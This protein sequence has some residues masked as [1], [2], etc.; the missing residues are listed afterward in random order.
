MHR[1][2]AGGGNAEERRQRLRDQMKAFYGDPNAST[3]RA[4]SHSST[5]RNPNVPPELDLDSEYFNVNRY[6]TDL[7]KRE[8]LK[9]LV[10][11]DTELLRR[12]RRLD[13]ELQELVYRNYARFIS[14][15]E[16]IREMKDNVVEMDA[17]LQTLSQNVNTIDNISSQITQ[18]L[19]VHRGHIEDTITANRM[20]KKVQF[21]TSL[22]TTMR[23]LID[24]GDYSVGV[25][26]WVAGDGFLSKHKS[27]SSITQIQQNCCQL[28]KEL[29][30]AIEQHMCS[31]PLD[32]PDAM[33][34]LRGYVEDLRLLRATSLFESAN[35]IEE[36][37]FEETVLQTLMKSVLASFQANVATTQRSLN[38][39]LAIP[40]DLQAS[41]MAK[42]EASLA[43]V[44]L[45]E[46]LVQLKNACAMLVVNTER[47]YALLDA[48]GRSSSDRGPAAPLVA[49]SIQPVL[50]KVLQ[51]VSQSLADF[52]MVHLDAIAMDG[53]SALRN[54]TA[55]AGA[56]QVATTHLV[57]LLS[58]FVTAM[59]T[60]GEIYLPSM[61]HDAAEA[62]GSAAPA[63]DTVHLYANKVHEVACDVV[64]QCWERIQERLLQGPEP[65]LL[66]AC[67]P[68]S[69]SHVSVLS[70]VPAVDDE[71]AHEI[72]FALTRF[73]YASLT[74]CLSTSL[75]TTLL[76]EEGVPVDM[77]TSITTGL[78]R[79]AQQLQHRGIVLLGQLEVRLV[80]DKAF[81]GSSGHVSTATTTTTGPKVQEVLLLLLPQWATVY[82][83][84]KALPPLKTASVTAAAKSKGGV[85][86]SLYRHRDNSGYGGGTAYRVSGGSSTGTHSDYRAGGSSAVVGGSSA[87]LRG[88]S[89]RGKPEVSYT[90]QVMSRLQM[91]VNHIFA[92]AETWLRTE[93][94][95]GLPSAL[96]ACVVRYLLQGI[97]DRVRDEAAYTETQFQQLQVSCTFLL[98]ALV[99]PTKGSAPR[100]WRKEWSEEDM[101]D[102]QRLLN[103]VCACAYDKYEAKVPL[104]TA[105]L[106]RVVETAVHSGRAA[107]EAAN[108]SSADTAAAT[109]VPMPSVTEVTFPGEETKTPS[110]EPPQPAPIAP[111]LVTLSPQPQQLLQEVRHPLRDDLLQSS[112]AASSGE[113]PNST[114]PPAPTASAAAPSPAPVTSASAP[115][116]ATP[117][118]PAQA[119]VT[120]PPESRAEPAA[121]LVPAAAER[122][123][124]AP[125]TTMPPPQARFSSHYNSDSRTERVDEEEELPL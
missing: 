38:A 112:A 18:Q 105:V 62:S 32:D 120:L 42:R 117:A 29:Y 104:P 81:S 60:L 122:L 5:Q 108:I 100:Q 1:G 121:S 49:K 39:A 73:L 27:I 25:K 90:R 53:A 31:Y 69:L 110:L 102:V 4:A 56:L 79:A 87:H 118:T 99:S 76:G 103:E 2:S 54:P 6:I 55:S 43:Q 82:D 80:Y 10:E 95:V 91:S 61:G 8:T 17:K 107:L 64:R 97:L 71:G 12:V 94:V 124:A 11:T 9:G 28:A 51:A 36:A 125:G 101:L 75:R 35:I 70:T 41:E 26:Y 46:P 93:P 113:T 89:S 37:P 30:H 15:T 21:L 34:R 47:V 19:Q 116:Q 92:N 123:A 13:G 50:L 66:K 98:H 52:A 45:R 58:Q 63:A 96:M 14:A 72:A 88:G 119:S 16:T 3:K 24:Q 115:A 85:S 111:A 106:D 23:R 65:E 20:L 59:K 57:R 33:D 22:P 68:L 67:C 84:L 44:N 40:D 109:A 86:S 114:A 74:Q 78:E 7:L 83:V 48:E 77:L